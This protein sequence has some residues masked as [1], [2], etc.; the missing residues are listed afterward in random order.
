VGDILVIHPGS[1]TYRRSAA[2]RQGAVAELRDADKIPKCRCPGNTNNILVKMFIRTSGYLGA[3]LVDLIR[4]LGCEA[5]KCSDITLFSVH[6]LSGVLREFSECLCKWNH[7]MDCTVVGVFV[8]PLRCC[9]KRRLISRLWRLLTRLINAACLCILCSPVCFLQR[10]L[11][12][13]A[14]CVTI[15]RTKTD[16]TPSYLIKCL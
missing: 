15:I 8:R 14:L 9:M 16:T 10:F 1:S 13:R 5:A 11:Y 12:L 4:S 3:L 2:H 7:Q 6:F